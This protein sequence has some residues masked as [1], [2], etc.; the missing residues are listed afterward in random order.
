VPAGAIHALL[1]QPVEAIFRT[2]DFLSPPPAAGRSRA[3]QSLAAPE[4]DRAAIEMDVREATDLGRAR[5][6]ASAESRL[7]RT[8]S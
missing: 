7:R 2:K 5:A 1:R 4:H 8:K 3:L 6:R